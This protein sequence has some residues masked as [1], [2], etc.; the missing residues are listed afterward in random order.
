MYIIQV[1]ARIELR[2]RHRD[3]KPKREVTTEPLEFESVSST[4]YNGMILYFQDGDWEI[5][6]NKCWVSKV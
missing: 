6:V 3:D 4:G 1:G 2:H 5:A